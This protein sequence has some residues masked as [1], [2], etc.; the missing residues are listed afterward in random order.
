[1]SAGLLPA[2]PEEHD[3]AASL[4]DLLRASGA[5]RPDAIFARI[6][7]KAGPVRHLIELGA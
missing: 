5:A 1:M 4:S 2:L 6:G 7:A 3:S